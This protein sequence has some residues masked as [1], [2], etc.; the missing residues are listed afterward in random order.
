MT[1][2]VSS[3]TDLIKALKECKDGDRISGNTLLREPHIVNK[4]VTFDTFGFAAIETHKVKPADLLGSLVITSGASFVN[5]F[6]YGK[7]IHEYSIWQQDGL[8]CL[9]KADGASYIN[10]YR[11]ELSKVNY[12]GLWLFDCKYASVVDSSIF[13]HAVPK[14]GYGFGYGIWQGGKGNAKDQVLNVSNCSF[15][16]NRHCIA[17]SKHP[18]H[19]YV[20]GCNFKGGQY[21]QHILDRHG[22]NGIGGGNYYIFGNTFESPDRY[23]YDLAKPLGQILIEG[24]TFARPEA[25]G[26]IGGLVYSGN[27]NNLAV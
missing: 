23:A 15:E 9:I 18:N 6:F 2:Q 12:C 21:S 25:N 17:G 13:N 4:K 7:T 14:E 5:C 16:N 22:E 24:N 20:T 27:T 10:L 1:Y 8:Q 11:T 19:I 26:R 3:E